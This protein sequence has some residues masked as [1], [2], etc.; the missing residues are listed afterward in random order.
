MRKECAF[1]AYSKFNRLFLILGQTF[2]EQK[3][4]ACDKAWKI[5][6]WLRIF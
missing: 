2:T 1:K 6:L 4:M 3:K 5:S